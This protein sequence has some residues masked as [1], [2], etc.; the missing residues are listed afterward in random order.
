[1]RKPEQRLWDRMRK[2][3]GRDVYLERIENLVTVGMPDVM[4]TVNGR[5]GFVELKSVEKF[6]AKFSTKVLGDQKGLSIAQRNW[7]KSFRRAGGWSFV[8][9]GVGSFDIFIFDSAFVDEVNNF[10][11]SDFT[12]NSIGWEFEHLIPLMKEGR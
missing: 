10:T 6:P 8:L 5:V 2:A 4:V 11:K 7:H 3:I 12:T 9:V 1:M